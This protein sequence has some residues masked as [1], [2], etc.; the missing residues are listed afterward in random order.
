MTRHF[1][2]YFGIQLCLFFS[3]CSENPSSKNPEDEPNAEFLLK[4]EGLDLE[5][6]FLLANH[7][8][9]MW[10]SWIEKSAEI[11]R[12]FYA[13]WNGEKL[14]D[15]ILIAEGE[16]WFVNWA[17]Y[18]QIA[19]FENGTFMAAFLQK[20]GPG[21]FSYDI[22]LTFS[23]DGK[24]WS[25]PKVLHDDGTQ[26]EHGFISMKPWGEK[27]LVSW[28]DGRNTGSTHQH[29]D[30]GHQ[31]QMSLRAAVFD[32]E[33]N[34]TQEWLLDDRVCDCC[35]TGIGVADNHPIIIFRD[36]SDT[37]IRDIGMVRWDGEE[38]LETEPVY[39]DL[40][41]IAACPVNGPRISTLGK[42]T[43]IAWYAVSNGNPEIKL[44]F[45]E[46]GGK[47]LKPP[48]KI[49]LGNTLGRI[50]LQF[51]NEQNV[52]ISWMEN[53]RIMARTVNLEGKLGKAMEVASSSEKRSSGFPQL[54]FDG[55][56][57]WVA[58]T[59]D[60]APNK[61]IRLKKIAN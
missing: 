24:Q 41:E 58:W 2:F 46:D 33:G 42:K 4:R 23:E 29:S 61:K 55:K 40:W 45:S 21:T 10:L 16:E 13:K 53:S 28:L 7:D 39:M 44:I 52:M 3:A 20:S 43:A 60:N 31:G 19:Q 11:N 51:I 37:E 9:E 25:A 22:M 1:L 5:E 26:T 35:Q 34:K 48:I 47:T 12:F 8:G 14:E 6:P 50:G 30:H 27:M 17:D 49:D 18:P 57:S 56:D 38:F 36:R 15:E 32:S 54:A 59:D